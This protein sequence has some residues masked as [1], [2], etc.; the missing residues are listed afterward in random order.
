[1]I[2]KDTF[3]TI[4]ADP[5]GLKKTKGESFMKQLFDERELMHQ[6]IIAH[7][8]LQELAGADTHVK[9]LVDN[10]G[11]LDAQ[12]LALVENS[13]THQEAGFTG[14]HTMERLPRQ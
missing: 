10:L 13:T 11:L 1:M 8:H 6:H 5:S 2:A 12:L 14:R 4:T 7:E 3:T 9:M